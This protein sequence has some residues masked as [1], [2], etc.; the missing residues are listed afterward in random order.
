MKFLLIAVIVI[1]GVSGRKPE[2]FQEATRKAEAS[3]CQTFV[4][5]DAMRPNSDGLLRQFLHEKQYKYSAR[6]SRLGGD[7]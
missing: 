3:R 7:L 5:C 1:V 6:R 2:G 4:L